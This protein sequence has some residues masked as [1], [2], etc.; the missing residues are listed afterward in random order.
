[1][2]RRQAH[3][4]KTLIPLKEVVNMYSDEFT[5]IQSAR[6]A[7]VNG[8][9]GSRMGC[10]YYP[11][12][13]GADGSTLKSARTIVTVYI[14]RKDRTDTNTGDKIKGRR[15]VL[16]LTGWNT[17]N[18]KDGKG[19][20]D[21]LAKCVSEGKEI[22]CRAKVQS[23]EQEVKNIDGSI[24]QRSDGKGPLTI[25][26]HGWVIEPG[27]IN[28]G[29]DSDKLILAEI[30]AFDGTASFN[31]RPQFWNSQGHSH[32][33]AWKKI[34]AWRMA[35]TCK[36]GALTYG[37]AV[38]KSQ[39][40]SQVQGPGINVEGV[41]AA[42]NAGGAMDIKFPDGSEIPQ[43]GSAGAAGAADDEPFM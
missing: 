40:Q 21:S 32:N 3:E 6:V 24:V 12:V 10:L 25:R 19:L 37:Y 35:Q 29:N 20:A 13:K 26:R 41:K 27:T 9:N 2:I 39:G 28:Y 5:V 17:R 23:Y 18:S 15:E 30:A 4:G 8:P 11:A 38:V 22:S 34:S 14:N 42:A 1:M 7:G 33:E 36:P 31:S 43:S 16:V